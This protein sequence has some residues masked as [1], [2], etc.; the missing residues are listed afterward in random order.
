MTRIG[1]AVAIA[2]GCAGTTAPAPI[3]NVARDVIAPLP[4]DG[5][6]AYVADDTGLVEVSATASQVIAKDVRWCNAD[7]RANVVWFATDQGVLAFDLVDRRVHPVIR[8]ATD[9]LELI[10]DWGK[11]QQLGGE[12]M[13]AFDVG[14]AIHMTPSPAVDMV[15]GCMGDRMVYCFEHDKPVPKVVALQ[16]LAHQIR[17]DDPAYVSTL[18]TRGADRSLWTPPPVP[19]LPPTTPAPVDPSRC[20]EQ[21]DRCGEWTAIPGSSLWL[22][23]T[24]NSRGDYYD[25]SR[26]LWD[27][28][29]S[30]FVRVAGGKLV[31]SS[32][33]P[34]TAGGDYGGLRVSPF[35]GVMSF[36]GAVF[37]A[38]KVFYAPH[39]D[40]VTCGFASGGWRIHGPRG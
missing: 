13:V 35:G 4:G 10:I 25:E 23:E 14:V 27:P 8:H 16:R 30:S 20:T 34:T 6:R 40:G 32:Q 2:A 21:P 7:A 26:E 5:D 9:Q 3:T 12:D 39:D 28:A 18:V 11:Y 22:V 24:G 37:D 33:I 29:T 31:R 1:F 17:L 15:M 19:P 38:T 36:H